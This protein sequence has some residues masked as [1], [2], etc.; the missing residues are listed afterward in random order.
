M[1]IVLEG[2][3]CPLDYTSRS[4]NCSLSE[5]PKTLS[6]GDMLVSEGLEREIPEGCRLA[7]FSARVMAILLI[8]PTALPW[9]SD[10][11]YD[12]RV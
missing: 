7:G 2:S 12:W 1:D 8:T 5:L 6:R 4:Y 11:W 3:C 10:G 9:T